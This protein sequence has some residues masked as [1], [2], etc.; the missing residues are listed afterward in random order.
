MSLTTMECNID[1][2]NVDIS[3]LHLLF[4][5]FGILYLIFLGNQ[6]IF[7]LVFSQFW[8][9]NDIR[10]CIQSFLG[11]QI[12]FVFGHF[13]ETKWYS[14]S[15]LVT[16]GEPNNIC[17]RIRSSKHY[18]LTSVLKWSF[19]F[20]IRTLCSDGRNMRSKHVKVSFRERMIFNN[21]EL[22]VKLS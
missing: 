16:F 7:S 4:P 11:S 8:K 9:L 2:V 22:F 5:P 19:P 15:Y 18:W 13:S 20:P 21:S 12:I 3:F 14:Y 1:T 10:I 17:I 6:I